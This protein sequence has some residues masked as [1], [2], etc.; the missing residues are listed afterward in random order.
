MQLF[1]VLCIV[2]EQALSTF[3]I[4]AR[5]VKLVYKG[6]ARWDFASCKLSQV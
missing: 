2:R 5:L 3:L 1:H 6:A 4:H